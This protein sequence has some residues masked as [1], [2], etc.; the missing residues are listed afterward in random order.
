MRFASLS[1]KQ[2]LILILVIAVLASTL[3]VGTIQQYIARKLVEQNMESVQLPNMVKQVAR[4]MISYG[5]ILLTGIW[6]QL[7][8]KCRQVVQPRGR[9]CRFWRTF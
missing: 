9:R 8:F 1:I 2:K 3:L 7:R 4:S 6:K 5:V